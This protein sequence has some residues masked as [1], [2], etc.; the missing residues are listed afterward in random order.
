MSPRAAL[1]GRFTRSVAGLGLSITMAAL[2]L[3]AI[4]A[5]FALAAPAPPT[6][7]KLS[8]SSYA[9]GATEVTYT[10]DLTMPANVSLAAAKELAAKPPP[11]SR[12]DVE[13]RLGRSP[14]NSL[15]PSASRWPTSP[16]PAPPQPACALKRPMPTGAN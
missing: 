15:A 13:D 14:P 7:A 9:A 12:V 5:P 3:V 1:H 6:G 10:V 16:R 2:S 4:A 8:L 11:Q